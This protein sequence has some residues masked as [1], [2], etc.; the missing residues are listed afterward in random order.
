MPLIPK[1]DFQNPVGCALLPSPKPGQI[2]LWAYASV[3]GG[4]NMINYYLWQEAPFGDECLSTGILDH[5]GRPRPR[6]ANE[7]KQTIE[8]IKDLEPFATQIVRSEAAVLFDYPS[9]WANR[10]YRLTEPYSHLHLRQE[11]IQAFYR[12]GLPCDLIDIGQLESYKIV[13]VPD[14]QIV[15]EEHC[16][17]FKT[18]VRNGGHLVMTFR[19]GLRDESGKIITD[20]LPGRL[21]SLLGATIE[22]SEPLYQNDT[23]GIKWSFFDQPCTGNTWTDT[24]ALEGAQGLGHYTDGVL[25][26]K[27]CL[28]RF[29]LEQG[30]SYYLGTLPNAVGLSQILKRIMEDAK[31]NPVAGVPENVIVGVRSGRSGRSIFL[32]NYNDVP[33]ECDCGPA[34]KISVPAFDTIVVK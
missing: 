14:M 25:A 2:R 18:F 32:I 23:V 10:T 34:G 26:G 3:A 13:V 8:E 27:I 12:A 24:L 19:G 6:L 17:R 5:A 30:F 28:S 1:E 22:E 31:V 33:V 4:A 29:G 7:L 11:F 9:W 20:P 21:A 16:E 15:T